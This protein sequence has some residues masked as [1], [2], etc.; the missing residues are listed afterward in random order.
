MNSSRDGMGDG[1][2]VITYFILL[3][4]GD[5]SYFKGER[6]WKICRLKGG[7]KERKMQY[8]H[9]LFLGFTNVRSRLCAGCCR[10]GKGPPPPHTGAYMLY[11]ASFARRSKNSDGETGDG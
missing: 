10:R 6:G 9:F 4:T 3:I 8:H 11:R 7:K 1:D 5:L 2:P